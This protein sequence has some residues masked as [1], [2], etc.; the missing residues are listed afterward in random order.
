MPSRCAAI[1]KMPDRVDTPV[2]PIPAIKMLLMPVDNAGSGRVI[3]AGRTMSLW[4]F[5]EVPVSVIKLGQN[6]LIQ[7]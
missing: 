7:E 3:S 5:G 2:P 1:T 4:V 6:P